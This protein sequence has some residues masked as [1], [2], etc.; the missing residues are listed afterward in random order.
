M[1]P[2]VHHLDWISTISEKRHTHT[3]P[4]Q[5][6][7]PKGGRQRK[8]KR[9]L[10]TCLQEARKESERNRN[11]NRR[12]R[13]RLSSECVSAVV[14][15]RILESTTQEPADISHSSGDTQAGMESSECNGCSM[16]GQGQ[17]TCDART[18]TTRPWRRGDRLRAEASKHCREAQ[19]DIR[20][21]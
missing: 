20:R 2:A 12:S 13:R 19:E 1:S 8:R 15:Y 4:L 7:S 18:R 9:V 17:R 21:R 3:L 5:A 6:P 16:E 10:E 14:Q 11:K